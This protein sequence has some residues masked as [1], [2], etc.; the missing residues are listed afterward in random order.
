MNEK[1]FVAGAAG[2]IG[3]R[4]CRRLQ[5]RGYRVYALLRPE[6]GHDIISEYIAGTVTGD[7]LSRDDCGKIES[8]LLQEKIP[9]IVSLVGGVDYH[10]DYETSRRINVETTEN[11]AAIARK[12][13]SEGILQKMVF[14]GSVASRGFYSGREKPVPLISEETDVWIKGKAVYGDVKREAEEIIRQAFRNYGLPAVIVQPGSLV[15]PEAGSTTTTTVGLARRSLKGIPVLS[16]GASYTSVE[17]V[18]A[19]IVAALERGTAGESYLLGGEN[20][21]MKEFSTLV[22]SLARDHYPRMKMSRFAP[23]VVSALTARIL[24]KGGIMMNS[25]QA[26]LGSTFHYIDSSKA[27][28]GLDYRHDG[29]ILKKEILSLLGAMASQRT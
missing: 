24:G 4:V 20:M 17:S 18:A 22:R 10:Q 12:V 14:G 9:F 29:D 16:G 2:F 19:G 15:G 3:I 1:V 6:E 7:L 11:I 23:P 25:Q 13:S 26:L 28:G 27:E 8:Y 21:T 5:E